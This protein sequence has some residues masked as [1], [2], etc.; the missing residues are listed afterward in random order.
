MDSMSRYRGLVVLL[1][2]WCSV[3]G[4]APSLLDDFGGITAFAAS[5]KYYRKTKFN[6]IK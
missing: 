5:G 6:G 3:S 4:R 2:I 1:G